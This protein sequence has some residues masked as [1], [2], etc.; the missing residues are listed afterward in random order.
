M[1]FLTIIRRI[2]VRLADAPVFYLDP[3]GPIM[4]T[5]DIALSSVW[6][7]TVLYGLAVAWAVYARPHPTRGI[8]MALGG[9]TTALSAIAALAEPLW[10]LIILVDFIILCL[11]LA[12]GLHAEKK[13]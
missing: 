13:L 2:H 12:T 7:M 4:L 3:R 10:G 9:L 5:K 1:L 8:W 11:V 6:G